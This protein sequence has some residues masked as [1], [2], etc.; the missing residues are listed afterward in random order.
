MLPPVLFGEYP[1]ASILL[2]SGSHLPPAFLCLLLLTAPACHTADLF[3]PRRDAPEDVPRREEAVYLY[4]VDLLSSAD[5]L[6]YFDDYGPTLVEWINDSSCAWQ[7]RPC[8]PTPPHA[9]SV[10]RTGGGAQTGGQQQH[11]HAARCVAQAHVAATAAAA[12][13]AVACRLRRF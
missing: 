13:A 8:R 11:I 10:M 6:R 12:A 5:V 4:G 9:M 2:Q 1:S 3:E 7:P